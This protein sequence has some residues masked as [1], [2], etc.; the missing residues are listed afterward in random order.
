[1]ASESRGTV[2]LALSANAGIAVA[3]GAAGLLGGSS[4]MLAEAAHSLADTTNQVFLLTALKRGDRAADAVHPFGYGKERFFWSLLAAVGI[5]VAGGSFSLYEGV[6]GLLAPPEE[7]PRYLLSYVVLFIALLL[8]GSSLLKALRQTSK[9][10]KE[11]GRGLLEHVRLS[12]DPT[13]KTVVSEDSAAVTG[14]LLAAAGL[15]LHEL[16][17]NAVWDSLAAIGVGLLLIVVAF[18]LG[19]DTKELLIGEAADGPTRLQLW[20]ELVQA[21]EVDRVIDLMTMLLGPESLLVAVRV[22]LAAD[23]DSQQ[24]EEFSSQ[25]DRRLRERVP[26]VRAVFLDATTA[27]GDDL[28]RADALEREMQRLRDGR[29]GASASARG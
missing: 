28:T 1:M 13:V 24:V 23:L 26:A 21:P 11:A 27:R 2:L 14:L 19:R 8:E 15:G 3:K 6:R 16:T 10:A 4:V 5:F 17:G 25:M 29:A 12:T 22:D 18:L 7:D 9:E 20:Q